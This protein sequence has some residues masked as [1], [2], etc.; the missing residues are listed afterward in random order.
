[1]S[2]SEHY[3]QVSSATNRRREARDER[4]KRRLAKEAEAE[5]KRHEEASLQRLDQIAS[6]LSTKERSELDASLA[7]DRHQQAIDRSTL[8]VQL[9]HQV[10]LQLA[11]EQAGKMRAF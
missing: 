2:F 10:Q 4:Y 1:M 7:W 6:G 8:Y 5:R 11:R 3:E 9:T